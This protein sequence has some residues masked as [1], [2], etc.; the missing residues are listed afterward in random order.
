MTRA[1][2]SPD[3]A[4]N[5]VDE[6]GGRDRRLR[7]RHAD[8]VSRC[9]RRRHPSCARY[10][11]RRRA[12]RAPHASQRWGLCHRRCVTTSRSGQRA[13]AHTWWW[14]LASRSSSEPAAPTLTYDGACS[15]GAA[16]GRTAPAAGSTTPRSARCSKQGSEPLVRGRTAPHVVPSTGARRFRP[17]APAPP[18]R[19][20]AYGGSPRRHASATKRQCAA[21]LSRAAGPGTRAHA[22]PSAS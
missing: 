4:P 22:S 13:H 11:R 8:Q 19:R 17:S 16:P 21:A 3:P 14:R 1:R 18:R 10:R 7:R 20:A 15:R 5:R 2:R 9:S 6:P 12:A